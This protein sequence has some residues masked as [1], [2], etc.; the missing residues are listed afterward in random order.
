MAVVI[1]KPPLWTRLAPWV[2]G[3]DGPFLLSVALLALLGQLVMLSVAFDIEGR[4]QD[5]L[6]NLLIGA[7]VMVVV[8][9]VPPQRLQALA[10]PA[11]VVGVLLLVAVELVGV[12]RKGAQRWLDLGVITLQPSELMKIAMPLMLAW[13]FQRREGRLR[14]L[15]FAVAAGLLALPVGLIMLQPDLGTALLVLASGL[16]VIYFAG[17]SWALIVPPLLLGALGVGVLVVMEPQWCA[18]GVD[19]VV[20]HEYQRQRVCTLLDPTRDPLGKG[21]HILQGLIAIGSGGVWGK[22]FMQGTQ[23]HL[24][25]VPERST[26]FIFAA[27]AEEFGLVGVLVL[28]TAYGV[29]I[30]RG[31]VLAM[32]ASTLFGRLLAGALILVQFVYAF[33]NIGMVSGLLPVVG[34]P[35]PFVSYGGTA[36]VALGASLGLMLSVGRH[37]RLVPT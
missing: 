6:R 16:F 17:L 20:L 5:H 23:T 21:F 24:D 11:Y 19:W 27:L 28:L 33:V 10:V 22:G 35:L 4:V 14:A 1:Q 8:A 34:V 3:F 30:W 7:V 25:F 15:D 37:K 36:M 2:R 18:P 12:T 26:D 32:E 29:F 31:L 13:W 9:Q